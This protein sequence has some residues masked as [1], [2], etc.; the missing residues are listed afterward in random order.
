MYDLNEKKYYE[1]HFVCKMLQ[2]I[3]IVF[4]SQ[5]QQNY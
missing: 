1:E 5:T 2:T 3:V 4:L